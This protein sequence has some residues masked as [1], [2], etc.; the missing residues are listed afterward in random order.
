MLAVKEGERIVSEALAR[1]GAE[2]AGC[3]HRV[4]DLA[5]GEMAVWVGVSARHRHEAFLAC[6]Y[7]IDEVKQR[8]PIW[9][10]EHYEDGDA[11][12]VNCEQCA[13]H[14]HAP[15][16]DYSRQIALKDV[17]LTGQSKL[18]TSR[19][20]V[21]GCGGLGVPA[22][23]YLAGAGVG[24]LG[25]V[26]GDRLDP[27]NL[28][29]QTFYALGDVGKLKAILAAERVSALNPEVEVHAHAV[30]LDEKAALALIPQYDLV[31]DCT[32]NFASKFLLN[33]VCL[34]L[35]KPCI[36][37]SVYQYEGQIQIL[38]PDLTGAAISADGRPGETHTACLRCIWPEA[39]RDGIVGNCSEAGVL[40]PVPGVFGSLQALEAMKILL[41]L[42][43]Q[44]INELLVLDLLTLQ[45]TR[46][47]AKR[48]QSCPD[49]AGRRSGVSEVRARDVEVAVSSLTEAAEAGY[50]IVDIREP[51]EVSAEPAPL[52]GILQQP[53][54]QVLHGKPVFDAAGKTLLVC[55]TGRRSLAAA[56]ELRSRGLENVFSL[57]GGL[58]GI[59]AGLLA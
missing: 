49:H 1:F 38:R 33:D 10:K 47:R 35:K 31:L 21:V 37:A 7:I 13:A 45:I 34:R 53:L 8:V 57:R 55:A 27:S 50:E 43:G 58:A 19:V 28:H 26:D 29:R 51:G 41:D 56:L 24:R 32:D 17:G 25:L 42:P 12:W 23:S 40:G 39:T 6:R 14:T 44:L 5:V 48:A 22:I 9:K 30:R 15:A 20:L 52:S 36:F 4:G 59:R 3:V 2:H 11:H 16:P 46:V 18:R 54:A